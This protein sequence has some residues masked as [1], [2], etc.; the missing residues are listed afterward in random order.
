[1]EEH[2]DELSDKDDTETDDKHHTNRFQLQGFAIL[3][4]YKSVSEGPVGLNR[5]LNRNGCHLHTLLHAVLFFCF[6]VVY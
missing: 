4:L 3:K 6:K 2:R 5:R 1:V